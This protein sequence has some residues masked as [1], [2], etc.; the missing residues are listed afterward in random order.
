MTTKVKPIPDG[1]QTANVYLVV[2]NVEKQIDFLKQAFDGTE[3]HRSVL[4]SGS[5]IHAEVQVGMSRIMMGQANDTWKPRPTT[6]YLYV[7]DADATFRKAVAAG[8]KA[9]GE[10][11]NQFYGDRSGGVQDPCDNYW[12]IATHIEDVSPE[13]SDRRFAEM[14]HKH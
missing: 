10:P 5:I 1:F 6:V 4:P 7:E 13:E 12:W 9:L 11:Q 2:D 8:A 14:G 3:L